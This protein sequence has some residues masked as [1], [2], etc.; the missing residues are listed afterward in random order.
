VGK[1]LNNDFCIYKTCLN[2]RF[3]QRTYQVIIA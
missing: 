2:A 3:L 1:Y